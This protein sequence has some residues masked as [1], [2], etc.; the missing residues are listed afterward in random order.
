[1][2]EGIACGVPCGVPWGLRGVPR[3]YGVIAPCVIWLVG[4]SSHRLRC[5][6]AEGVS[7][8]SDLQ[9]YWVLSLESLPS[10]YFGQVSLHEGKHKSTFFEN[11]EEVFSQFKLLHT[12]IYALT[13][14]SKLSSSFSYTST[15]EK[16]PINQHNCSTK[17][18]HNLMHPNQ[19]HIYL[20]QK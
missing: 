9:Q 16:E 10:H 1:M 20:Y 15:K 17:L 6:I 12:T 7:H 8:K 3:V 11:K 2:I 5:F 14:E 13:E 18:T 19:S 4:V